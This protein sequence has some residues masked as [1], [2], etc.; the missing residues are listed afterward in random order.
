MPCCGRELGDG[1]ASICL[2]LARW[3]SWPPWTALLL[4]T[5]Q[6]NPSVNFFLLGDAPPLVFDWPRNAKFQRMPLQDVLSQAQRILKVQLPAKLSVTGGASKISDFKPM[7]GEL[8]KDQL[9]G[10]DFWGYVQEDMLLGD[11]RAFL[12]EKMLDNFDTISPLLAPCYHAGPF[13]V[14]RNT[15]AV[16]SLFR[17]SREWKMVASDPQYMAF[18]EWWGARLRDH[19]PAVVNREQM[20]G[21]AP[22]GQVAPPSSMLHVRHSPPPLPLPLPL[23]P[24]LCHCRCRCRYC[25]RYSRYA[26]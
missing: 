1:R 17:R 20:A 5:I 16:R 13:M 26:L 10:C 11:L 3:G 6:M 7:F 21:A 14:Y 2:F 19:M 12:D 18:D 15:E 8:F 4:R 9:I 23:P 24:L 22:L 25:S